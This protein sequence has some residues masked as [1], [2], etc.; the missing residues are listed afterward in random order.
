MDPEQEQQ[1]MKDAGTGPM[2]AEDEQSNA[3]RTQTSFPPVDSY[4]NNVMGNLNFFNSE[5]YMDMDIGE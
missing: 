4:A 3:F 1:E 2:F 5:I